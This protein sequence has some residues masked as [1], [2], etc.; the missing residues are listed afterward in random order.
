MLTLDYLKS[1]LLY[2]ETEN[3]SS[4]LPFLTSEAQFL[5]SAGGFDGITELIQSK[6]LQTALVLEHNEVGELSFRPGGFHQASQSIWIMRMVGFNDDRRAIQKDTKVMMQDILRMFAGHEQDE[7][8]KQWEWGSVPYGA[9]NAG[10]NYTGYE[11]T[12]HFS[13]DIDLS[14]G[15]I[16]HRNG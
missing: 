2:T 4:G 8:L 12:L 16:E 9:R 15:A 11:F 6:G 10:A 13:E 5:E 3:G 7:P 1:I 14:Y